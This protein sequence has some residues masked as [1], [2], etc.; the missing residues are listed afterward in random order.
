MATVRSWS[1]ESRRGARRGAER[2]VN[3]RRAVPSEQVAARSRVRPQGLPERGP[4]SA[5]WPST[6]WSSTGNTPPNAPTKPQA[7]ALTGRSLTL[8]RAAHLSRAHAEPDQRSIMPRT[9]H[10]IQWRTPPGDGTGQSTS[11]HPPH[12]PSRK[13]SRSE[14]SYSMKLSC[15]VQ[16]SQSMTQG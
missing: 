9:S 3:A 12:T 10:A 14:R 1:G 16:I 7:S 11:R 13:P 8:H 4:A 5:E 2:P 15:L 6:D